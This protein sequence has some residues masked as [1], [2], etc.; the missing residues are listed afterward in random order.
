M[1]ERIERNRKRDD[2]SISIKRVTPFNRKSSFSTS[3]VSYDA[4]P[5]ILL[6]L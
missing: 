2:Y 3:G 1:R 6:F 4:I 5:L